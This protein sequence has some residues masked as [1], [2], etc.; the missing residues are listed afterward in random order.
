MKPLTT[1]TAA[2]LLTLGVASTAA[3]DDVEG[4]IEWV[5]PAA[6]TLSVLG[7]TFHTTPSTDYV[8]GRH[9]ATEIELDD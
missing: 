4:V 9:I 6:G 2:G 7:I 5:D 8:D 1:L 3:A